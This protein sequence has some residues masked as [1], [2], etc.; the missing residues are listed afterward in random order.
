[1]M[2]AGRARRILFEC[3]SGTLL[4]IDQGG[5]IPSSRRPNH[6]RRPGRDGFWGGARHDRL[7]ARHHQ[8]L[9]RRVSAKG[10][11]RPSRIMRSANFWVERGG[12]F[13]TVTGRKRRCGWFDAVLVRQAVSRQ[14]D[15]RHC[16]DPSST[17][18]DGMDQI[19]GLHRLHAGWPAHRLSAGQ[20]RARR[21]AWSR[22]TRHWKDGPARRPA[23]VPGTTFLPRR[24]NMSAISRNSSG[25]RSLC[26]RPARSGTTTILVT[27]PLSRLGFN[28]R[29]SKRDDAHLADN[30]AGLHL[31][32]GF[33][34]CLAQERSAD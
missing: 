28:A 25:R 2:R 24:S 9:S 11:F 7:C 12:E 8:G 16:A 29:R 21:R 30:N 3:A 18:L 22:S 10:R 14:R 4:D 26:C 33:R 31:M 27:D 15:R 5:R 23:P 20:A 19:K 32:G 13:G 17:C 34:S 1:M 6:R